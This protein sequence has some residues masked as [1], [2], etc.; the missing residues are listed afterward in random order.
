MR[1]SD[2]S[3]DVCSSDLEITLR[4][5]EL[6]NPDGTVDQSNLRL[7]ECTDRFVLAG[8][9]KAEVFEPHFTYHGFRYVEIE[10]YP[11]APTA[12][13]IEGIVVY[14]ACRTRSEEHTSELQSLMRIS[15]AVFCLKKKTYTTTKQHINDNY[16]ND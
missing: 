5:A 7:A 14:S 8:D 1:I 10:C 16:N 12:D 6:L 11:G 9:S 3:S 15:Y 2:W 4:F 13:D